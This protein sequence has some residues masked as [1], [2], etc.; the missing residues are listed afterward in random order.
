MDIERW[1]KYWLDRIRITIIII[2]VF[3]GIYPNT[4]M[5]TQKNKR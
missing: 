5:R 2:I 3:F 1:Q 4:Y